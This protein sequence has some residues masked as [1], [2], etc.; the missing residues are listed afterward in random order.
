MFELGGGKE[1]KK[2]TITYPKMVC[3][4]GGFFSM[5]I[6]DGTNWTVLKK[7]KIENKKV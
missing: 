5:D 6:L 4:V 2:K 3:I 7:N 1:K